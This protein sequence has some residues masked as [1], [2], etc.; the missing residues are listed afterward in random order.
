MT[1][2]GVDLVSAAGVTGTA[3]V[4][5]V[6]GQVDPASGAVEGTV[7]AT[8]PVGAQ[9]SRVHLRYFAGL[10]DFEAQ[11]VVGPVT[12]DGEEVVSTQHDS[13]VTVPLAE[14]HPDVVDLVVPFSYT[15]QPSKAAGLFDALAGLG[16][17]ADVGL[18]GRHEDVVNL[19]H[20][21][22]LWVPAGNNVDPDP[23][24]YGDIGN[25][26]AAMI[27]LELRVPDGW[28]VVDGGVRTDEDTTG[29]HLTITS[30]GYGMNDLAVTVVRGYTSRSRTLGGE[31]GDVT[32][33]AW[34][35]DTAESELDGV[36]DEAAASL[37][38]LSRAFVDYP[39]REFDVVAAPLGS[40]VGGM[41]WPGATWIET[42]LFGGGLPGM[43]GLEEMLGDAEGFGSLLGEDLGSL[44]TLGGVAGGEMGKML[45]TQRLWTI[46][47]EV[48]HEWWHV[49]VGND[50]IRDPVVD[51]P[52]A[53]YSACLV[54]R[55]RMKA[56]AEDLCRA[57]IES[58][59]EQMRALGD[60]DGAVARATDE[61][62]SSGQYA[63][64]VYGKAAAFYLAL[65][66]RYGRDAVVDALGAVTEEHAFTMMSSA[67]LRAAL[68]EQL[69][70]QIADSRFEGVWD[71]WMEQTHGDADL[72]FDGAGGVGGNLEGLEGLD[73]DQLL[74]G[75]GQGPEELEK[76]L[77]QL[78][79]ELEKQS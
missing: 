77:D 16:G 76:V 29:S 32:V 75:S 45:E 58:G 7:E 62:D 61:F 17:P 71:R 74:Q 52:L 38:T 36:L 44:D 43:A 20:W 25:F 51:E 35:P 59:Y 49:V 34:G 5:L 24:G 18:L 15:V 46:A 33:T 12:V 14:S 79:K 1:P 47:H 56:G 27:R 69:G 30:E 26:P 6:T 28:T 73:F 3:P 41:E 19:G 39:W 21:F 55:E 50:S 22:P 57:H 54:L 13:I 64:V 8:L 40:G 9:T 11:A 31:L 23:A 70:R 37:Q 67:D 60:Q 10:P 72:G 48:G 2:A 78:L 68:G 63:G 65:E 53:Q 66:E 42:G 4:Y